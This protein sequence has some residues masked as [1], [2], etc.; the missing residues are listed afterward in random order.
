MIRVWGG[1]EYANEDFYKACDKNGILV[2][3][4][5][6]FA[7]ALYPGDNVFLDNVR[8]E[9]EQNIKRIAGHPSL[10]LFCGNNEIWEGWMN[11]GLEAGS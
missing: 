9:A 2:W 10:A 3:Q 7:C 5:F 6:P 1:S 4:D 11:W 8:K